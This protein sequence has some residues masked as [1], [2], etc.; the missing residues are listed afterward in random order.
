MLICL[1]IVCDCF[2]SVT[3]TISICEGHHLAPRDENI[4]Y[5]ALYQKHMLNLG[6]Y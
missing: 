3:C 1:L 5:L 4:Y 6:L 2:H